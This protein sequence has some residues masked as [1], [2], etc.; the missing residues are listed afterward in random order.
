[1]DP[2]VRCAWLSGVLVFVAGACGGTVDVGGHNPDAAAETRTWDAAGTDASTSDGP[3]IDVGGHNPDATAETRTWDAAGTDASTSDGPGT[4]T[5]APGNDAACVLPGPFSPASYAGG[6]ASDSD[7]ILG[8]TSFSDCST[9][10]APCHCAGNAI[11]RSN[12]A[13]YKADVAAYSNACTQVCDSCTLG[14]DLCPRGTGC[15]TVCSGSCALPTP[16]C[17][18]GT[19]K[20]LND[21][22]GPCP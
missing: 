17:C 21:P 2:M 20:A 19:C 22:S 9:I 1:M 14:C 4:E 11:N 15:M 18:G 6:C 3:G 13:K 12:E 8:G 10:Q 5:S 16:R 7:C